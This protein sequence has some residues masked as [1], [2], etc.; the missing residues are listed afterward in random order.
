LALNALILAPALADERTVTG[1]ELGERARRVAKHSGIAEAAIHVVRS[2]EE[3]ARIAAGL[4]TAPLLFVRATDHVVAMEL[5]RPLLAADDSRVRIAVEAAGGAYAGAIAAPAARAGALLDALAADFDAGGDAAFVATAEPLRIEVNRRARHPAR[6]KEELRAADA[7]QFELV[8]KP[9]DAW[10]TRYFYR[11]LAR[12][13]TRMF[14]HLPF[15]PN[16][17]TVVS[18]LLSLLGCWI[19]AGPSYAAHAL[20]LAVLVFGGIVDCNDGEVARL[21]LEFSTLGGWLDAIGD[22][23][24]RMALLLAMGAHVAALHP[25]WPVAWLTGI[26]LVLTIASLLL[27]YWYCIFVIHSSNNQDYGQAL[28]VGPAQA[29]PTKKSIGRAIGDFFAVVARRD[30]MDLA[31]LGCALVAIPAVPWVGM[32]AGGFISIVWVVPTHLKIVRQRREQRAAAGQKR[33]SP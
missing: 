18:A 31:A 7:W 27:I 5:T 16:Q 30:S 17:I 3:L 6:T 1:L 29:A 15:S 26:A 10:L 4:R 11:P 20:G 28:G 14:L 8:D 13:L 9:L 23:L 12:P 22:D 24:A 33:L 32:V 19:A 21:R 2:A 25:E